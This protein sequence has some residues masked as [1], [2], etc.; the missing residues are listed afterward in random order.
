VPWAS[1]SSPAV[2]KC[3]AAALQMLAQA[4]LIPKVSSRFQQGLSGLWAPDSLV[5]NGDYFIWGTLADI[6]TL[7]EENPSRQ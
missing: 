4:E 3:Q 2:A 5:W 6:L 7:L 1:G